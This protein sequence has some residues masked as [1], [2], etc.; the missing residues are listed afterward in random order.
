MF[1]SLFILYLG[2]IS[3]HTKA[4]LVFLWSSKKKKKNP[5]IQLEYMQT[6]SCTRAKPGN[7]SL[8]T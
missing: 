5:Q 8:G 2:S 1:A 3:R 4:R 6:S 7:I